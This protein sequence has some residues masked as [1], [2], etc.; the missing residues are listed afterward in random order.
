MG[1]VFE[2][3]FGFFLELIGA[4]ALALALGHRLWKGR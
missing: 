2:M 1:P 4:S 3:D